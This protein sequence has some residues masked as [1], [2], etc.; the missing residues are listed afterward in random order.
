[1]TERP[2]ATPRERDLAAEIDALRAELAT[3][4]RGSRLDALG[5]VAGSYF[6]AS[7]IAGCVLFVCVAAVLITLIV[8]KG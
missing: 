4:R 7:V 6:S 5:K 2:P 1:M 3:A 8:V